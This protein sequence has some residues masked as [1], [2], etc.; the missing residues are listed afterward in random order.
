MKIDG[1]NMSPLRGLNLL[2]ADFYKYVAP[3]ALGEGAANA[4]SE[5]VIQK[6]F[7]ELPVA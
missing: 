7:D 4:A 3:T 5:T 6:I 1:Q 2:G